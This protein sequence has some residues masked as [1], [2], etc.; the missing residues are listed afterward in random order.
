MQSW[1]EAFGHL[2]RH[3][4]VVVMTTDGLRIACYGPKAGFRLDRPEDLL[5][6]YNRVAVAEVVRTPEERARLNE[7]VCGFEHLEDTPFVLSG[8]LMG[9]FHLAAR[10]S[11][12]W[13]AAL[14]LMTLV[15]LYC[16]VQRERYGARPAYVCSTFVWAAQHQAR[17]APLRVPLSAKADDPLAYT[18]SDRVK[19]D[20]YA[21]WLC[22]PTELW[23]AISPIDRWDLD[24]S[25]FSADS[26]EQ[27]VSGAGQSAAHNWARQKAA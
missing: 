12:N 22:G 10:K 2:W 20:R 19:D 23:D 8:P 24:L 25:S 21:R 4:G 16:A 9:P 1:A 3:V 7:W 14:P 6:N 27:A 18:N 11:K 5:P 26:S 13:L 15:R 17:S